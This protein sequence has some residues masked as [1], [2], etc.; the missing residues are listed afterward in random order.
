MRIS[1][2]L[3]ARI[4]DE[5]LRLQP[6]AVGHVDYEGRRYQGIPLFGTLGEVWLLRS[7]GSLW[8]SDSDWGLELE[9]LPA[10]LHII[11]IVAGQARYPWLEELLPPRPDDAVAC[12]VCRGSGRIGGRKRVFCRACSALGWRP[13]S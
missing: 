10:E 9:P 8:R 11:A 4:E 6:S 1:Q 7:D 5:I 2:E 3:S 12:G 13:G